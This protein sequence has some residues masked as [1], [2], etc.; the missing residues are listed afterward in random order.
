LKGNQDNLHGDVST[1]LDDPACDAAMAE[2]TVDADHSRIETRTATV[3]TNIAWLQQDHNRPGL[4]TIG[5]L[6]R[7]RKA[8]AKTTTETTYYLLS[9]A[10]S[11]ERFNEVVREHRCI[12]NRLH[13][14]LDVE[15][16]PGNWTGS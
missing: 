6:V 14:R 13:W 9:A 5:K 3:S 1:Y 7:I 4:A 16:A 11:G 15:V 12:E 2:P 8:T 10:L